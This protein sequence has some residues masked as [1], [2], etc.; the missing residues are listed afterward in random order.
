MDRVPWRKRMDNT[1]EEIGSQP[2]TRIHENKKATQ[3]VAFLFLIVGILLQKLLTF[4]R[5][6]K[7]FSAV[8]LF[9]SHAKPFHFVHSL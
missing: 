7:T 8:E 9:P 3:W 4:G 1:F 5:V 2:W 6:L